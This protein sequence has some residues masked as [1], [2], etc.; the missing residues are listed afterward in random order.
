MKQF[1]KQEK[2]WIF[3][4]VANSSYATI[5]LAALFPIF[6]TNICNAQGVANGGDYWWALGNSIAT[7]IIAICAPVIGAMADIRGNKKKFFIVFLLMGLIFSVVAVFGGSWW[8]MLIGYGL[9]FIGFEGSC[10]VNDSF[11]TDVTTPERMDKVSSWAY[12]LGYIGGSTIPF[13]VAIALVMF[14]EKIGVDSLKAVQYSVLI[15]VVWWTVFSIPMLK[16]VEQVYYVE[17][18]EGNIIATSLKNVWNTA[19]DIFRI[20]PLFIFLLSYFFYIDG[21]NTVIKMSTSYGNTLGLGTTGMILA[22]MVTQLVAFP[23]S[24]LFGKLSEKFGSI[25]MLIFAI[26]VYIVICMLGFV[27]GYGL[28]EEFLTISQASVLF[29]ILATLVG[30]VQGGIQAISR[31]HFGKL[32]PPERSGE[33]FG[34]FDIFGKFAAVVGPTLYAGSKSLTGR[35]S[36]SILSLILLFV[37]GLVILL[38]GNKKNTEMG[39]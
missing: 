4:D 11:L 38:I 3:Y 10:L 7:F 22:L 39:K 19:K 31:S 16:N 1:S 34:F 17:K 20:K 14:G 37:I 13:L 9:S 21:V 32:V 18:P 28:E 33:F 25:P 2:S 27:M 24:I 35:S 26:S 29:W 15:M 30:T 5:M 6:F 36:F 8:M 23:C 12:A